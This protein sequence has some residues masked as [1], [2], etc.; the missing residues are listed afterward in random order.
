MALGFFGEEGDKSK[1]IF[2]ILNIEKAHEW[3]DCFVPQLNV[4]FW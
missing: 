4:Q 2:S 3:Y 1:I